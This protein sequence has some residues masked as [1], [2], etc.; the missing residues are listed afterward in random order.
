[1]QVAD[2]TKFQ[3]NMLLNRMITVTLKIAANEYPNTCNLNLPN[4]ETITDCTAF[5]IKII[6]KQTKIHIVV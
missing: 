4:P 5:H 2:I 6:L 1:M 3:L